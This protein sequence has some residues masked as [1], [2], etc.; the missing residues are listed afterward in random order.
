MNNKKNNV[1]KLGLPKGSLQES[2]LRLFKKAG[3][4]IGVSTR[5]YYPV[6]DDPEIESMLIRAQEMARYVEDGV[7]DCGLTGLD[8][9]LEQHADVVEIAELNYA[10]EGFRPVRWVVAVPNDSKIKTLKDLQGKRVATELVGFTKRYLKSKGIKAEV[11][12]SW[13][14][15]EVK[16]PY[17]ADAIVELTETGTS[18]KANNLRIVETII[19]STTRFIANKKA[20]HDKW[21]RRKMEN[22]SLLLRGAL[23]A[24]EKVGLK[25]NV[26]EK[27]FKKVL[28]LLSAMH[29][30]TVSSLSDA[31]WY[32]I[33]VVIDER[34]VRDIIP[35]L[36]SAGASGIVEY[37]LNKVVP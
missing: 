2:T 20:W 8:W 18:L 31:G 17:L 12:F 23:A 16:P 21:K 27:A 28:S 1:L 36:K 22:L 29:S 34:T 6:F 25:M 3:Y 33:D 26:P 7:L 19:E 35:K 5:S 24:E 14:A 10:K 37:Q 9:V 13:G 30:P 32:A 15:T 11:D 4:H